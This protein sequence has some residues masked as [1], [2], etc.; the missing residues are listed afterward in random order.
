M[1]LDGLESLAREMKVDV[2]LRSRLR[3][4]DTISYAHLMETI[5]W[6]FVEE[7]IFSAWFPGMEPTYLGHV[8][9]LENWITAGGT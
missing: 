8:C 1:K 2:L 9:T 6:G 4:T 3:D 7:A 5:T